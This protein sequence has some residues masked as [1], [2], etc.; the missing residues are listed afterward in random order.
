M[1]DWLP[2]SSTNISIPVKFIV[3]FTGCWIISNLDCDDKFY[4]CSY[5]RNVRAHVNK[6]WMEN[7]KTEMYT[8]LFLQKL[9][10]DCIINIHLYTQH[11]YFNWFGYP[12][13]SDPAVSIGQYLFMRNFRCRNDLIKN[14]AEVFSPRETIQT[15]CQL[16]IN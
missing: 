3:I 10:S 8:F 1:C 16:Y 14:N 6:I 11:I 13:V 12:H 5:I 15:L 7:K 9:M 2:Q 4:W